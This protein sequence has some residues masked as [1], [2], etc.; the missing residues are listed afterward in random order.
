[1]TLTQTNPSQKDTSKTSEQHHL[2][3]AEHLGLASTAHA[4]A[5]KCHANGDQ[6]GAAVC[7]KKAQSHT[8]TA[9]Q[10]AQK[11][12]NEKAAHVSK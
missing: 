4:D 5:A 11:A 7:E 10:H 1:M 9:A 12:S 8:A 2:K 3:A 6:V